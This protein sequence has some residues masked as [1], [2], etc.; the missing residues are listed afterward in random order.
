VRAGVGDQKKEEEKK[1]EAKTVGKVCENICIE[2][3]TERKRSERHCGN[4]EECQPQTAGDRP[5]LMNKVTR[6]S[7]T[8][9]RQQRHN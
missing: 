5:T 6:T 1:M 9:N 4:G 3:E 8:G 7:R 2:R